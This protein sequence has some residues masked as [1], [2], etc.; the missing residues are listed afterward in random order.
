MDFKLV[1]TLTESNID[2]K[3][4]GKSYLLNICNV[5]YLFL[6]SRTLK[7]HKTDLCMLDTLRYLVYPYIFVSL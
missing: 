4:V 1:K 3:Y 6:I 5:D 7:K 2:I